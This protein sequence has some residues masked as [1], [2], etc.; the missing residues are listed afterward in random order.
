MKGGLVVNNKLIFSREKES[1]STRIEDVPMLLALE[2]NVS[3]RK[4]N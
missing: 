1:R 2:K 3:T 4:L